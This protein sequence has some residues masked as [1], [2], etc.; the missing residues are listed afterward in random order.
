MLP[1]N[2]AIPIDIEV[3]LVNGKKEPWRIVAGVVAILFIVAMWISKDIVSV[4]RDLPK[5]DILP[6]IF[7]TVL[8]SLAKVAAIAVIALIARFLYVRY[9]K[10]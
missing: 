8:V 4:Y 10:K 2:T 6:I 9:V 5:E 7:T 3:K 1:S